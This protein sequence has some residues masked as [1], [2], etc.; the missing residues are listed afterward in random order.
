MFPWTYSCGELLFISLISWTHSFCFLQ[1]FLKTQRNPATLRKNNVI[2]IKNLSQSAWCV[3]KDWTVS[4]SNY[5]SF[6]CF[7]VQN[8]T[9]S[10][11][12]LPFCIWWL[13]VLHPPPRL[14]LIWDEVLSDWISQAPRGK[15]FKIGLS[16]DW[17]VWPGGKVAREVKKKTCANGS[18]HWN[19]TC[20][21][22]CSLSHTHTRTHALPEDDYLNTQR[23]AK[24]WNKVKWASCHR[25]N[26]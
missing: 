17:K 12:F 24:K 5:D 19:A 14:I 21:S 6:G 23:S 3:F 18:Y 2:L 16:S 25:H 11:F 20:A 4:Y 26:R 1:D 15:F 7:S 8:Y 13:S 9:R 22:S 10:I